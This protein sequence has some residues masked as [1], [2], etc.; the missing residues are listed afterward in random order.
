MKDT[1][2]ER[3]CKFENFTF[4]TSETFGITNVQT[5]FIP[6]NHS[7]RKERI[8]EIIMLY[9]EMR[10]PIIISCNIGSFDSVLN[11]L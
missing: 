1:I 4:E 2:F 5:Q 10:Q 7:R 6:F 8:F 9:F 3:T 11:T